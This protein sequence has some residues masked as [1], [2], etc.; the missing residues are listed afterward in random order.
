M[1]RSEIRAAIL[2]RNRSLKT[3]LVSIGDAQIEVRQPTV[4]ARD[5]ITKA[6]MKI[7]RSGTTM[8]MDLDLCKRRVHALIESCY[9]PGTNEKVFTLADEDALNAEPAGEPWVEAAMAF[10]Q[11][12][13]GKEEATAKNSEPTPGDSSSFA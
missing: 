4:G 3:I 1:N 8:D 11:P 7:N 10:L 6:G 9:V 12:Y 13:L 2:G 5:R